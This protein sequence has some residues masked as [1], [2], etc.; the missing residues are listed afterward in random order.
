[1]PSKSKRKQSAE[2][3]TDPQNIL[4]RRIKKE[5]VTKKKRM[6]ENEMFPEKVGTKKLAGKKTKKF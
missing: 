4:E 3:V 6:Y 2:N 1:M 5:A